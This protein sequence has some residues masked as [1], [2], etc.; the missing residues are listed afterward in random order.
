MVWTE[1]S[2]VNPSPEKARR[3]GRGGEVTELVFEEQVDLTWVESREETLQ[4]R[5][6]NEVMF[7]ECILKRT[8]GGR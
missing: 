5:E 3:A 7:G 1:V 4:A 8:Y 6:K 2:R